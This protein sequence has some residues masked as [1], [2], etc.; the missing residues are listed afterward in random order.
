VGFRLQEQFLILSRPATPF[1]RLNTLLLLVAVV[2]LE[3]QSVTKQAV[4]Q[5]LAGIVQ[6]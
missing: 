2:P 5:V 1:R 4:V 3:L 6:V